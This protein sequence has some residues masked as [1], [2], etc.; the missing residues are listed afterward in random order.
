MSNKRAAR[1]KINGKLAK[2]IPLL[3]S[4]KPDEV[5][6]TAQAIARLLASVNLDFHDLVTFVT[7]EQAPPADL[8]RSPLEKDRDA[9]LHLALARASFFHSDAG[10][11]FADVIID[12]H[13]ATWQLPSQFADF[14]MHEFFLEKRRAPTAAAMQSALR[15][16]IAHAR[17][18]GE[19]HDVHLRVAES[20]RRIYIDLGDREWRVVE[21]DE[22]DWRIVTNP[23]VRFRRSPGMNP[24]PLPQRGGSI[25]QLRSFVNLNDTDFT[26]LVSVLLDGLRAGKPHPVLFLSGEEG[27]AKSTLAKI[28]RLL[29]DP[30]STPLRTLPGTVRDLFVSAYNGYALNFDNLSKI[31]QPMSDALCQI[32]TGSGFGSRRLYT[33]GGEFLVSGSRPIVLN[34][35]ANTI[36]RSDLADRAIVLS[37]APIKPERRLSETAFWTAFAAEHAQI[38]GA[39]LDAVVYGLKHEPLV[40]LDRLPRMADFV[41]RSVASEGAFADRGA[42][43]CAFEASAVASTDTL[44][45]LD[46]VATAVSAFMIE[47]TSWRGT[48]TQLLHALTDGDRTEARVSQWASW[49]RNPSLF[50]SRL[51]AIAATLRKV[52][53]EILFDKKMPDRRRTR[54]IELRKHE[55]EEPQ[56]D[57]GAPDTADGA[58]NT[59]GV[60]AR[61]L[62]QAWHR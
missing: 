50:S 19:Q 28:V 14:L 16:L 44:I 13:R 36:T 48:A 3:A 31:A 47:R 51:R 53:I 46:C 32:A 24:L 35:L 10:A 62:E 38:F 60:S 61:R 30:N 2:L 1:K 4:D 40:R 52:N 7:E 23:P 39:M 33:D 15:T 29:L 41:I 57:V 37:L 25:H 49:P 8:L 12:G 21:I 5:L 42:F 34:G 45:E 11:A 59:D 18:D 55:Q 56:F 22:A 17:F 27:T 20:N 54:I 6:N 43:L 9:L 58:D 26:L